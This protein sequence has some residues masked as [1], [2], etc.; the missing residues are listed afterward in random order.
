MT[1]C[2]NLSPEGNRDNVV[3]MD[4]RIPQDLMRPE[5]S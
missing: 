4:V 5:I 1:I 2:R 3:V